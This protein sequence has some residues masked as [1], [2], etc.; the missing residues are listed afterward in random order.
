MPQSPPGD[1][2]AAG[3]GRKGLGSHLTPEAL[4]LK[5]QKNQ[6]SEDKG[7]NYYRME[8][9][10][11]AFQRVIPLPASVDLSKWRP[12]SRRGSSPLRFPKPATAG[13]MYRRLR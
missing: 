2:R 13:G 1:G 11:G 7:K 10:Y 8:R 3:D 12:A 4:T 9:S 6:E 5:G